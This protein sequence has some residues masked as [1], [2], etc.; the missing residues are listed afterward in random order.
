MREG[1]LQGTYMSEFIIF[2]LEWLRPRNSVSDRTAFTAYAQQRIRALAVK[3]AAEVTL[4]RPPS[5]DSPGGVPLR[6]SVPLLC[7]PL[8][9]TRT[10]FSPGTFTWLTTFNSRRPRRCSASEPA[11]IPAMPC[12]LVQLPALQPGFVSGFVRAVVYPR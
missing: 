2:A 10:Q 1:L 11:S 12:L 9:D 6:G 3:G 4:A 7:A 8:L 5:R